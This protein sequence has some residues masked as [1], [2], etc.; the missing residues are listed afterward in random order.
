[1]L[2][3]TLELKT[4]KAI[5]ETAINMLADMYQDGGDLSYLK[6]Q[7]IKYSITEEELYG[8]LGINKQ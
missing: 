1:M 2:T 6:K 7:A 4:L 8:A 5:R 3:E